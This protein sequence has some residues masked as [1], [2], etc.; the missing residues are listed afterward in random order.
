MVWGF[1]FRVVDDVAEEYDMPTG[2]KEKELASSTSK[3]KPQ[4]PNAG[5]MGEQL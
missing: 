3:P 2:W 4:T 1:G 5:G